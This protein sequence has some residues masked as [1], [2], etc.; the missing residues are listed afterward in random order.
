MASPLKTG[1]QSVNLAGSGARVSK[2]RRDPPPAKKEI[3]V[4]DPD[5]IDRQAVVVGVIV[6]ALSLF[7]ITLAFASYSGWTPRQYTIE[8]NA[9]E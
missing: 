3:D 2:I 6:F 8:W 7:V 4:R 1:K 5:E 9:A